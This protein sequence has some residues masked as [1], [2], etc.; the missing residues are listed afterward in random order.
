M[1]TASQADPETLRWVAEQLRY[2][3]AHLAQ[4]TQGEISDFITKM[5]C[6]HADMFS[7]HADRIDAARA[8]HEAGH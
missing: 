7:K 6:D 1:I 5:L 4:R 3:G 8:D 2:A